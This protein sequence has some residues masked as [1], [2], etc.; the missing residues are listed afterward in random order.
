MHAVASR[1]I[2]LERFEEW[3]PL[4]IDIMTQQETTLEFSQKYIEPVLVSL[5]NSILHSSRSDIALQAMHGKLTSYLRN[6]DANVKLIFLSMVKSLFENL[7][8]DYLVLMPPTLQYVG[9][10][11]EDND[12][13]VRIMTQ[14]LTLVLKELSGEDISEFLK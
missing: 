8:N 2:T 4:F 9:E 13:E 1:F 12:E 11:L 6:R 14:R 7:R 3:Y 10:L 5:A